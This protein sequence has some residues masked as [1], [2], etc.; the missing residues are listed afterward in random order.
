LMCA[1]TGTQVFGAPVVIFIFCSRLPLVAPCSC[2][3]RLC[4]ALVNGSGQ[5]RPIVGHAVH[6]LCRP[7]RN[8]SEPLCVAGVH[9][10]GRLEWQNRP[11]VLV[12]G[13]RRLAV[14]RRRL[15]VGRRQLMVNRSRS[16]GHR[17]PFGTG[18]S[19]VEGPGAR[20]FAQKLA[21]AVWQIVDLWQM[22]LG[23]GSVALLQ[24]CHQRP[25]GK[26]V[27]SRNWPR[28]KSHSVIPAP[29]TTR[30]Q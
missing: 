6:S 4:C 30:T 28:T 22:A 25:A 26:L 12:E 9:S 20:T 3:T 14:N 23:I 5:Q 8:E 27:L 24:T 18:R 2:G 29:C 17:Q 7:A 21:L 16:A 13:L 1:D 19:T 11:S 10:G 15:A